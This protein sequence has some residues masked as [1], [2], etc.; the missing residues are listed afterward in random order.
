M[1]EYLL[2]KKGLSIR[3]GI[4]RYGH[5]LW[6][7][8]RPDNTIRN[9]SFKSLKRFVVR[10]NL[11]AYSF[12]SITRVPIGVVGHLIGYLIP[13]PID[14]NSFLVYRPQQSHTTYKYYTLFI[15]NWIMG[16]C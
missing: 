13:L 12:L 6:H 16:F 3:Y 10:K 11:I 4:H 9:N 8:I 1:K 15:I 14:I 7:L 2:N 5:F